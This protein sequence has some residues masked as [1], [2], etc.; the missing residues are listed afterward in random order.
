MQMEAMRVPAVA[1]DEE[2]M[3]LVSECLGPSKTTGILNKP[4]GKGKNS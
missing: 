3:Q 4:M 2:G 1:R